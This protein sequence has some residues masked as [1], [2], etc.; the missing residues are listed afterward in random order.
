MYKYYKLLPAYGTVEIEY[1]DFSDIVH[2]H[3]QHS[4]TVMEGFLKDIKSNLR[5]F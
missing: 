1:H 5:F 3:C 4:M 2:V